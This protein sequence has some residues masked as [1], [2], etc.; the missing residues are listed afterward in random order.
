M[1]ASEFRYLKATEE[2]FSEDQE[3]KLTDIAGKM[4]LSKA[5]VYRAVERLVA[6]GYLIRRGNKTITPTDKGLTALKEYTLCIDFIKNTI[7][8]NWKVSP[9]TAYTD[10]VN[11]V[12]II[13]D[14]SRNSI[15]N[16]LNKKTN[17]PV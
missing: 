6:A 8:R 2:L 16:Y 14:A 7:E 12:C 13:S 9:G 15:L 17:R 11:T 5:S 1:T 10:A 3:V 4:K